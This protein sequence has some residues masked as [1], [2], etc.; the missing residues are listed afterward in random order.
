M[1]ASGHSGDCL[2]YLPK[3]S[4]VFVSLNCDPPDRNHFRSYPLN[5]FL[6]G[7]RG[8]EIANETCVSLNEKGMIAIQHQV[9]DTVRNF[10]VVE[11]LTQIPQYPLNFS[12]ALFLS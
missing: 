9:L 3:N 1:G 6:Q 10:I 7:M 2:L 12:I 5:S 11:L 8:L 4:E